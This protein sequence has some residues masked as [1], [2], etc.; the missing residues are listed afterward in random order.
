MDLLTFSG[1]YIRNRWARQ[2]FGTW[3]FPAVESVHTRAGNTDRHI[4][5][6]DFVCWGWALRGQADT[7]QLAGL[8]YWTGAAR[9]M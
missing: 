9:I 7:S 2:R 6:V 1:G 5:I 3:L 8:R 4:A